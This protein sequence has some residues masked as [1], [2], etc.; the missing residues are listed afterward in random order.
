MKA[1]I[2]YLLGC[3]SF[4]IFAETLQVEYSRFY[5][6]IR[7][8][9]SEDTNALQF[10]FG[11][12]RVGEGRLCNITAAQIVTPK[13]TMPLKITDEYRFTVQNEKALKLADAVVEIS[14][15]EPANVCDMS[16]QLETK[17]AYLK[18][19]Y[20]NEE[21]QLLLDQ[22]TAFFNEMGSFLSF[23]MPTVQGLNIQ[24][25]DPYMDHVFK[26]EPHIQNGMLRLDKDWFEHGKGL[27]LPVKPLRITAIASK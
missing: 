13:Q 25:E 6:H 27:N 23:M 22:Y 11:F 9:N 16:V 14:L 26:E 24:F 21:L 20:S 2:I 10:A 12:L 18:K 17:P 3:L 15:A 4:P 1:V 19:S 8:L 7:K 5:S